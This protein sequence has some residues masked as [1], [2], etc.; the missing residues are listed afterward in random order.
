MPPLDSHQTVHKNMKVHV[1]TRPGTSRSKGMDRLHSLNFQG[2]G[3][4]LLAIFIRCRAICQITERR[5]D[6]TPGRLDDE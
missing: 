4:N 1:E 6:N 5:E 3:S 2:N